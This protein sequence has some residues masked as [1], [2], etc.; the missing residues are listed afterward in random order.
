MAALYLNLHFP[1]NLITRVVYIQSQ[2]IFMLLYFITGA[3]DNLNKTVWLDVIRVGSAFSA[4][5]TVWNWSELLWS[6]HFSA[7]WGV[8]IYT[9]HQNISDQ[10][11]LTKEQWLILEKWLREDRNNAFLIPPKEDS[12]SHVWL[13]FLRINSMDKMK[14]ITGEF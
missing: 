5:N 9:D 1:R 4:S 2:D 10:I 12:C 13:Q 14:K 8:K 3:P 6:H 7:F 11:I